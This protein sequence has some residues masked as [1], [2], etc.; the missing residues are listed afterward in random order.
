MLSPRLALRWSHVVLATCL[1]AMFL[2]FNYMPLYHTDIW[3]HVHWGQW[4][5]ENGTLPVEDPYMPLAAG[6]HEIN[7]AWLSQ[8]LFA[9]AERWGGDEA[10]SNLYAVVLL[11]TYG[12]LLRVFYVQSGRLLLASAGML[13]V[14]LTVWTRNAIIRPEIFGGLCFALLLWMLVRIAPWRSS[15]VVLRAQH[16]SGRQV[17]PW[18]ALFALFAAWANLHG[19]F[20]VGLM[21]LAAVAGGTCIQAM[22]RTRSVRACFT[23]SEAFQSILRV[24]V[25]L[26]ATLCNPYG[27]DLLIT[28][29]RFGSNPNLNEV[30]EWYPLKLVDLE[31]LAVLGTLALVMFC[32]RQS[33]QRIQLSEILVFVVLFGMTALRVRM[34]NWYA[35]TVIFLLMP[36][37]A[38]AWRRQIARRRQP[39]LK[40][41][42]LTPR[43]FLPTLA[44]GLVVWM[45]F[46]LS[47]A[48]KPVL[49]GEARVGNHIYSQN[50]PIAAAEFLKKQNTTG[51]IMAPQ[52]W[53]D[54]IAL[55]GSENASVFM[56]THV[57]LAPRRVWTDYLSVARGQSGWQ[58]TLNKYGVNTLVVHK[59][60]QTNLALQARGSADWRTV[61]EDNIAMILQRTK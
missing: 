40:S 20:A 58:L 19:S 54:W 26:L 41:E 44:C 8:V 7:T 12:I 14:L 25:A 43:H 42:D 9:L 29:L 27:L 3:G 35:P 10:L 11:A 57:H 15:A 36:H 50:T 47:P 18:V 5:L 46:S 17:W 28:T 60:L 48:S 16:H 61:Y 6:V 4:I 23:N 52:W 22:W 59:Q 30:L 1:A 13:G 31:G 49:G 51:L 39:V 38:S 45:T 37:A 34:I 53:G 56:T 2:Y 55:H 21:I 33:K 32:L 24:E